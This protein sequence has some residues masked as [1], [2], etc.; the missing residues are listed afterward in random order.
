MLLPAACALTTQRQARRNTEDILKAAG[1][2]C[3]NVE[4]LKTS[5]YAGTELFNYM[6]G[7]A[8]IYHQHGFVRMATARLKRSDTRALVELYQL[9]GPANTQKLFKMR[10]DGTSKPL[11]AGSE[12]VYWPAAELEGIFR[13]GDMFCR[14]Y[15]YAS[16]EGAVRM[17][18]DIASAVDASL[19]QQAR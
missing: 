10:L 8:E 9:D 1:S 14:V 7:A 2:R 12:G 4:L 16:D 17:L 5:Q 15:V 3:T 6:N 18:S 13:R 19:L 11:E